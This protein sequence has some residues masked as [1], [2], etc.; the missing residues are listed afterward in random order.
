M[1]GIR[2]IIRYF[3]KEK[4]YEEIE[5]IIEKEYLFKKIKDSKQRLEAERIRSNFKITK[6]S[7]FTAFILTSVGYLIFLAMA[8]LDKPE[9]FTFIPI[10]PIGLFLIVL[11]VGII[12]IYLL[13]ENLSVKITNTMRTTEV[14]LAKMNEV[15]KKTK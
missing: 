9:L 12:I 2:K 3:W 1:C 10:H 4:I 13:F 11:V 5:E 7:I 15:K 14:F 6:Y 8:I